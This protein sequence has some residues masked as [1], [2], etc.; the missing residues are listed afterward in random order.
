MFILDHSSFEKKRK[1]LESSEKTRMAK[2]LGTCIL[3][4]IYVGTVW[5]KEIIKLVEAMYHLV[6]LVCRDGN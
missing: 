1:T 6:S 4:C 3:Y 5:G 2:E